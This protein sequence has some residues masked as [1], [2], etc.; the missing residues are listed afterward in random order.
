MQYY[1]LPYFTVAKELSSCIALTLAQDENITG[2]QFGIESSLC[3]N[4]MNEYVHILGSEV[5]K[6]LTTIFLGF[7][8]WWVLLP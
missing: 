6:G 2:T 5:E 3:L 7:E 4:W 1:V 8:N